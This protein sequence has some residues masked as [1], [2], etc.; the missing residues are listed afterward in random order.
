ME[1]K[2]PPDWV[3]VRR[4]CESGE[5]TVREI[6]SRF[7]VSRGALY[8]RAKREA[9]F[10][11]G[12]RAGK[13]KFGG[14]RS[15]DQDYSFAGMIKA[16]TG[17]VGKQMDSE[18]G[19]DGADLER[20]LRIVKSLVSTAKLVEQMDDSAVEE[21]VEAGLGKKRSSKDGRGRGEVDNKDADAIRRELARRLKEMGESGED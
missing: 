1:H 11:R 2:D 10:R 3:E 20:Q 13:S 16:V 17:R 14:G 4:V 6:C 19:G 12:G 7:A 15:S 8:H 9:W 21:E 5:S 18:D